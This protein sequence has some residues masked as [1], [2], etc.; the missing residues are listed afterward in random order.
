VIETSIN[1]ANGKGLLL[2]SRAMKNE[3]IYG[4][5]PVRELLRAGRRTISSLSLL[6]TRK[7]SPD[8]AEIESLARR[9]AI[10]VTYVTKQQ[11]DQATDS[12]NHQGVLVET[13]GYPFVDFDEMITKAKQDTQSPFILILDHIQD[14]QNLGSLLRTAEC[15]GVNGVVI[16]ADRAVTVTP[17]AVR[18]SAGASEWVNVSMVTNVVRSMQSRQKNYIWITGLEA[19]PESK[20]VAEIDFKGAVGLVVGSEGDGMA[21]LVRE[22]CDFLLKLPMTGNVTSYNAAVA[23][24]MAMY[25]VVRQRG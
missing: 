11:L 14:P 12:R 20:G 24:A 1:L 15:I 25:E 4:R 2:D 19:M 16:P 8:L 17:T 22:T 23:G 13:S 3:I 10:R 18:A 21:R 6:Q 5:Q 7:P 9:S